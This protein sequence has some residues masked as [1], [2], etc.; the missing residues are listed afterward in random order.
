VQTIAKNV[1]TTTIIPGR[2]DWITFLKENLWSAKITNFKY[3]NDGI[4][5]IKKIPA[6][7]PIKPKTTPIFGMTKDTLN[8][9]LKFQVY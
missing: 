6:N 3:I 9:N 8:F 2:M 4:T 7:A 1:P 5:Y